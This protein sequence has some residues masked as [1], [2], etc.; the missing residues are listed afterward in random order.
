MNHVKGGDFPAMTMDSEV[1]KDGGNTNNL[2]NSDE[3]GSGYEPEPINLQRLADEIGRPRKYVEA[4]VALL[5]AGNTVPFIARYRK[6][7]TGGMDDEQLRTLSDGV[8][9]ARALEERRADVLRLLSEHGHLTPELEQE[10]R[11]ATTQQRLED[12]YRPYR[13][14]RKTRASVAKE[15]GL[16]PLA[17]WLLE[18]HAVQPEDEAAGYVGGDVPDVEAA[19]QGAR[20]YHCGN[21]ERRTLVEG[22]IAQHDQTVRDV[23]DDAAGERA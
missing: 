13:P 22:P 9:K 14:K 23:A 17:R 4:A 18:R 10:V 7:Q 2:N 5:D 19:L 3:N 16:E 15:R 21:F 1:K 11:A 8:A 20:G 12:L 6:E